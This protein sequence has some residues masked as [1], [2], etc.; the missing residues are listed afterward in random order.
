MKPFWISSVVLV[1]TAVILLLNTQ[2]LQGFVEPL[3]KQLHQ[4][5]GFAQAAEWGAAKQLTLEVHD[6]LEEKKLYLHIT[7]PHTELDQLYL[8]LTEAL[9]YLEQEKIGEYQAANQIL[10]HRLTLLYEM[11]SLTLKNLL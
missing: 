2:H 8:L 9:A 1:A 10:I 5:E 4:A 7:L 3:Q 6:T 11:E